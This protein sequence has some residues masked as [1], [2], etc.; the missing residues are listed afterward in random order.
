MCA[1]KRT[2]MLCGL[3]AVALLAGSAGLRG[4][5]KPAAAQGDGLHLSHA[6]SVSNPTPDSAS[7]NGSETHVPSGDPYH[8]FA[9]GFWPVGWPV[10]PSAE[11]DLGVR[12]GAMDVAVQV[13]LT[14][15]PCNTPLALHF[16]MVN[17]TT[18]K[19]RTVTFEDGFNDSNGDGNPDFI[20]MYPD[21]NDRILGPAQPYSRTVGITEVGGRKLLQQA[22][23]YEPGATVRGRTLDPALGRPAATLLDNAG[24]PL[25]VPTPGPVTDN[26]SPFDA[27]AVN[28]GTAP[29][30]TV[31]A[32]T[33]KEPGTYT[34]NFLYVAQRDAD[35]DGIE[36]TLDPC[37]LD[38]D[39]TWDPRATEAVGPGDADGD[40]LP[41]SCDPDDSA[42]VNDQD[43]DGF[44]NRGDNCP[45]VANGVDQ[46]G[47]AAGDQKDSD[48]DGIG[49]AC[50]PHPNN[51]DSEG[52][53]SEVLLSQD[54][55]ITE[56][57]PTA[58]QPLAPSPVASGFAEANG[59]RLYYEV[60]GD[61][62]PLLLIPGS[63]MN[64][65]GWTDEIP[66]Y[67]REF[68]VIVF[69]PRG[70]GQS[71][72][73]EGVDVTMALMADDAAAL[74]DALG[75]D[76]AHVYGVSLGGMVAQ[77]MALRH[78]EKIRSLI[79]GATTPGGPHAVPAEDWA[80]AA[81]VAAMTQGV[82]APNFLEI[83]FSPGYL[84][85]HRSEAVDYFTRVSGGPPTPPQ[86]AI[87][88]VKASAGHDTYDRLP[89]ITAPTLVLDGADDPMVPAENSRILAERIPG[90]ELV[91]LDGARHGY[92]FEKQAEA[93]AAVLDF[94]RAHSGQ[95]PAPAAL[96][97]A[98]SGG[99]L[100]EQG[101]GVPM[102]WYALMAGG[103]SLVLV[104]LAGVRCAR[105]RR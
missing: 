70:T 66:V 99:L 58:P 50:D 11:L 32:K 78:P 91:L 62:E 94:L 4:A 69:D 39:P 59:A 10:T 52:E 67:A 13:G 1:R 14:N 3:I 102:W 74:L 72:F 12:K 30:G 53:A 103:A 27:T 83:M 97:A 57:A 92:K 55:T 101:D 81:F 25:A 21:F 18:D 65:L 38:P 64:H 24:D 9:I 104:G 75:V 35:G 8:S 6:V 43:G 51:A 87:A 26:C 41:S 47:T 86:V 105:G 19:S 2:L 85:E 34:F 7:D 16:D 80:L 68:K 76:A 60:Y 95:A 40:G 93:N 82:E 23:S 37:P 73:P 100:T 20:D 84:A 88:Q 17:A 31:I 15:G 45:L 79:L 77:E 46:A 54:V 63:G 48:S 96:P 56:A 44:L 29:D 5:E 61:G 22:L 98:G 28:F 33:P 90:A 42:A 36:N 49:D 89:S 71:S